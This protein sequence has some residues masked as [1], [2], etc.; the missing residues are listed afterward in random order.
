MH[1]LTKRQVEISYCQQD[2]VGFNSLLDLM[3]VLP[4]AEQRVI[5]D[6]YPDAYRNANV[7]LRAAQTALNRLESEK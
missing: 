4:E 5:A 1:I 2:L 6:R 7:L 3:E